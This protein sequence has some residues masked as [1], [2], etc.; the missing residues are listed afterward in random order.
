MKTIT[1][2][3]T[4]SIAEKLTLFLATFSEKDLKIEMEDDIEF[5]AAKKEL[6]KDYDLYKKN[7]SSLMS[8]DDA[9]K[10]MD[11]LFSE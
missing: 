10:E 3:Y 11:I 9:E 1:L 4:D 2:H 5:L 8:I 7:E 6:Q